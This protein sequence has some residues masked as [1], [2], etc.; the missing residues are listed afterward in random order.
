MKKKKGKSKDTRAEAKRRKHEE[1]KGDMLGKMDKLG[2]QYHDDEIPPDE[3]DPSAVAKPLMHTLKSLIPYTQ[4]WY[5]ANAA[6]DE[7]DDYRALQVETAKARNLVTLTKIGQH[8][9]A[10]DIMMADTNHDFHYFNKMKLKALEEGKFKLDITLKVKQPARPV[11]KLQGAVDAALPM[12]G[13]D[14]SDTATAFQLAVDL[15]GS[16]STGCVW[17]YCT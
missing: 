7:M 17:R 3:V 6:E 11:N 1:L 15:S 2:L 14:T 8:E 5:Q 9:E 16:A 13:G 4:E 12:Y 10:L